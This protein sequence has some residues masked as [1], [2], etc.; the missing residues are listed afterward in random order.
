MILGS[1]IDLMEEFERLIVRKKIIGMLL[2]V[3]LKFNFILK[4][5]YRKI[6]INIRNF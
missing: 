4:D 6:I 1:D 5:K 3:I 2:V